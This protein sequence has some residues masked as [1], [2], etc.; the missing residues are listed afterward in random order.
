MSEPKEFTD[1]SFEREWTAQER[2]LRLERA[3]AAPSAD[4]HVEQYRLIARVLRHSPMAELPGDFAQQIAAR[5]ET[6]RALDDQRFEIA[7]QRVLLAL[8]ITAGAVCVVLLGDLW[9]S[10]FLNLSRFIAGFAFDW[11]VDW[12]FAV[13]FCLAATWAIEHW[14]E[15]LLES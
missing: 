4:A 13:V 7:L 9:R 15:R 8:L 6:A 3:G 14:R 10:A 1:E 12:L 5:V 11:Q 2:A